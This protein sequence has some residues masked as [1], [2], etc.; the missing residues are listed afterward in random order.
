VK[1]IGK[2][3]TQVKAKW[4]AENYKRYQIYLRYD[5]DQALIDYIEEN[6]ERTGTSELFRAALEKFKNEGP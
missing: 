3:S 2:T 5:E 1:S 6:K 4:N